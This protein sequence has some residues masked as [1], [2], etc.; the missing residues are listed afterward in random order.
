[1]GTATAE[2]TCITAPSS[3]LLAGVFRTLT[4]NGI[5]LR[6]IDMMASLVNAQECYLHLEMRVEN[7]AQSAIVEQL[8]TTLSNGGR[9]LQ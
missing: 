5:V 8:R 1:M 6:R 4:D 9:S 2:I 3:Q 7:D